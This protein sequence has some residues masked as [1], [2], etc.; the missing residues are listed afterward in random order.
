VSDVSRETIDETTILEE[1]VRDLG[2][3]LADRL[4]QA[5][6]LDMLLHQVAD[7]MLT[8]RLAER[9]VDSALRNAYADARNRLWS[10]ATHGP[11]NVI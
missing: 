3:K 7:A 2:H 5:N 1:L 11:A 6:Q 10:S 8:R 4:L 9:G